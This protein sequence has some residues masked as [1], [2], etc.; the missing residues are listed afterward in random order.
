MKKLLF[1]IAKIITAVATIG[2][3]ALWFDSKFDKQEETLKDIRQEVLY[4]N[5][6]QSMMSADIQGIH[7]TLEEIEDI[8]NKN[9]NKIESLNWAIRNGDNFTSAQLEEILNREFARN[10]VYNH[11]A[12]LEFIPIE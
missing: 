2:G 3:S 12:E 9:T 6:E 7:D 8:A 11:N 5:A 4:I 1:D 10:R